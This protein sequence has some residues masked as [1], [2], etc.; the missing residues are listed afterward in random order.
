M[1]RLPSQFG[2][3]EE[4]PGYQLWRVTHLWQR[5]IAEALKDLNLTH[6]Q[7]VLLAVSASLSEGEEP[8]NQAM[9][10]EA[11][12]MDKMMTSQVLRTLEEKGFLTRTRHPA[13]ARAIAL[14]VTDAGFETVS[15]AILRVEE[16]D[17]LFFKPIGSEAATLARLLNQLN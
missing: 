16:A 3:R 15:K 8:V 5:R 2:S 4:S 6:V 7:F 14:T 12:G 9:I 11:A 17:D 1:R 10:A 13:D